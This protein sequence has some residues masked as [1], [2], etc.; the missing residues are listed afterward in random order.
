MSDTPA[1]VLLEIHT[2]A[3]AGMLNVPRHFARWAA[4]AADEDH[5]DADLGEEL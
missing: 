1:S 4:V 3:L 5:P 2:H